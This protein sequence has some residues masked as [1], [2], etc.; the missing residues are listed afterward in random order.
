MPAAP[1]IAG[2]IRRVTH[3]PATAPMGI[4]TMSRMSSSPPST[5]V[6]CSTVAAYSGTS[7]IATMSATPDSRLSTFPAANARCANSRGSINGTVARRSCHTNTAS[8]IAAAAPSSTRVSAP[9]CEVSR[10]R[11]SAS[12]PSPT[13]SSAPPT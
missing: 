7:T 11:P 12:K 1:V 5:G 8:A 6:R 2:P 13:P 10:E 4:P 3:P 9:P